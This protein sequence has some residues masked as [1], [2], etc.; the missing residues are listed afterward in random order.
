MKEMYTNIPLVLNTL[1]NKLNAVRKEEYGEITID[2]IR[3]DND[4]SSSEGY[5]GD[6]IITLLRIEE[7]TS[8]KP[9][10]VYYTPDTNDKQKKAKRMN[11]DVCL[12]LYVLISSHAKRHIDAI[13]EISDVIY[14]MNNLSTIEVTDDDANTKENLIIELQTLSAEQQN[15]MW[16]TLGGNVVP[17]VVYK[18]R[19]VT[20]SSEVRD[21]NVAV[22]QEV[23][24][25][26]H[27]LSF[28]SDSGPWSAANTKLHQGEALTENDKNAIR[29]EMIR[30]YATPDNNIDIST[31]GNVE[32]KERVEARIQEEKWHSEDIDAKFTA[33]DGAENWKMAER[34]HD[35]KTIQK[36]L[37][38]E[39]LIAIA[40]KPES[41]RTKTE[42]M[43]LEKALSDKI[44]K[45]EISTRTK[46]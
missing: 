15:S 4:N 2:G 28:T 26:H 31:L 41:D 9:Q 21:E 37:L 33:E 19:M 1:C 18:I 30:R 16:Q 5:R 6:I 42:Q 43:A 13:S 20:V 3:K 14:W 38:I 44:I 10:N 22:V 35:I 8:H 27:A 29:E 25:R 40:N 23:N 32:G 17:S 39:G 46:K 7:E 12:N 34:I 45:K 36:G 11:P 24:S